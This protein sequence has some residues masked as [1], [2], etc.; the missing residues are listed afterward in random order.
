MI[1]AFLAADHPHMGRWER[2][3][4]SGDEPD[5]VSVWL[6][7]VFAL[8]LAVFWGLVLTHAASLLP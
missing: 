6:V 1:A 8:A 7:R 3:T 5:R 4:D 2:D